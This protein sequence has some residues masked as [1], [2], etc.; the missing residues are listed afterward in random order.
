MADLTTSYMG[1]KLKNPVIVASSG[2]TKSAEGIVR[3]AEAGAG[4][5]VMKSIFEEQYWEEVAPSE[6][7]LVIIR[8]L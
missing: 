8:K 2:L 3:C 1:L 4:A 5:V 6:Q 7:S